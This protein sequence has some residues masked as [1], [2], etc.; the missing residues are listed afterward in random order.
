M[1]R[2]SRRV[3]IATLVGTTVEWY[4]FFI[5]G[6]AAALIFNQLFFP[7]FSPLAGTLLSFATFATGWLARPIGGVLA[8]H[9]GDRVSRKSMLVITVVGMGIATM[10]VGVLPT[11]D[12]I[13]VWAPLLLVTLRILQGLAVGGE[14]GG[15]VVMA[16]EHAPAGRRGL[17]A[18]W[19]QM[20]VPGGLV[21]GTAVFY[22]FNTMP[23][24]S[25]LAW[26]WR[27]PFLLSFVLVVVGLVIRMRIVE[28]PAFQDAK[29]QQAVVR[30]PV[31]DVVR[32]HPGRVLIVIVAHIAPNTYFYTF[33]TFILAYATT[34][35]G[36]P[37]STVL[38][39][40]SIAALIETCT[41]PAFAHLSDRVGRRP[42]YIVGLVFLALCAFP[43]FWLASLGSTVLLFIGIAVCLGIGHSAVYGTQA[44]FF[45]ELFPTAVRYTG[46]SLGYQIAGALFGGPL[47]IIATALVAAAGG[48]PWLFA[49]YMAVAA[50]VSAFAAYLAPETSRLR[51]DDAV[52]PDKKLA[53]HG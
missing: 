14:Y 9:F 53:S 24:A 44:S 11:Y 33:A 15:A 16:V 40:V 48:T 23:E 36:Y 10:L 8:G 32:R 42:V 37:N 47:P 26:G 19:P 29:R 46:L 39:A 27:I 4:D 34:Q 7:S 12:S 35:L 25:F 22:L 41:L 6:T 52:E 31:V 17:G 13:D 30:L 21:L 18:A 38:V 5:Y 43:F 50:L 3:A 51:L 2:Q 49:G 20:G 28:S 45:S 1:S